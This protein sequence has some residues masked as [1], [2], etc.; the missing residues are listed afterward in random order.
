LAYLSN[1][2]HDI[3]KRR[4]EKVGQIPIWESFFPV[5]FFLQNFKEIEIWENHSVLEPGFE[6][7][8]F[9][10]FHDLWLSRLK[11]KSNA[12]P[13]DVPPSFFIVKRI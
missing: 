1:C 5:T 11:T 6:Y 8:P 13:S 9:L 10:K 3:R 4:E 2:V 12:I 7:K